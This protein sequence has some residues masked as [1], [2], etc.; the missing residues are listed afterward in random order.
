ME[1]LAGGIAVVILFL[2]VPILELLIDR[3]FKKK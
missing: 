1:G 2:I 3:I